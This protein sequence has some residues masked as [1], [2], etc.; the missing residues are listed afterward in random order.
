MENVNK[1]I[2]WCKAFMAIAII[3]L[4]WILENPTIP[5]TILASLILLTSCGCFCRTQGS[6]KNKN[7][8]EK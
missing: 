7:C 2:Y 1:K 5:I 6:L 4:V 3:V 8:C